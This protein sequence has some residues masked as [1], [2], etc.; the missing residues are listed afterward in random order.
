MQRKNTNLEKSKQDFKE[1]IST[2]EIMST[3]RTSFHTVEYHVF[4][5]LIQ[6]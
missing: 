6:L 5:S 3:Q 1:I 2:I 4:N